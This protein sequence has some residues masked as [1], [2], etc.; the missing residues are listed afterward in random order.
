MQRSPPSTH[1]YGTPCP[2]VT[3]RSDR[4]NGHGIG[5]GEKTNR[6]PRTIQTTVYSNLIL[7]CPPTIEVSERL[8]RLH[9][10][11]LVLHS[12]TGFVT[13]LQVCCIQATEAAC[14]SMSCF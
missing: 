3:R 6:P 4:H 8:K 12:L 11:S 14:P 5:H 1:R 10:K 13:L 9:T 2:S 7:K